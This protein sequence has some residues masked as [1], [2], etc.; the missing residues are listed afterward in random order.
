MRKLLALIFVT[1]TL[2][3]GRSLSDKSQIIVEY[4]DFIKYR[5][6]NKANTVM[7]VGGPPPRE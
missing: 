1:L 6:I 3:Y 2:C 4:I 5:E 7:G